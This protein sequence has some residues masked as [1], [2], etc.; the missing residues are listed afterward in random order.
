MSSVNLTKADTNLVNQFQANLSNAGVMSELA[1][2]ASNAM[3]RAE[4]NLFKE[5]SKP[6]PDEAQVMKLKNLYE[7]TVRIFE[8]I[9][10]LSKMMHETLMNIIRNFR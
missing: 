1:S 6:N 5:M 7:K 3:D 4:D 10:Q 8:L 9:S 2:K